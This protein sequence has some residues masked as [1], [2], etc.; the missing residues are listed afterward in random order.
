MRDVTYGGDASRI[1]TRSTPSVMTSLRNL[2]ISLAWPAGW[3]NIAEAIDHY[4]HHP[5]QALHELGLT[6]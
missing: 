1:R 2:A 6:T 4:R 3:T 5:D